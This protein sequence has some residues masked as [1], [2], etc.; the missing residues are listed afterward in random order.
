MDKPKDSRLATT[1]KS[2]LLLARASA[3]AKMA[4]F[5]HNKSTPEGSWDWRTDSLLPAER[6]APL[7]PF[8]LLFGGRR[9]GT[10]PA[11]G[12]FIS[13]IPFRDKGLV[14]SRMVQI[15]DAPASRVIGLRGVAQLMAQKN[16]VSGPRQPAAGR[17][18]SLNC[19]MIFGQTAG[20]LTRIFLVILPSIP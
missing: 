13:F 16:L 19:P 1:I 15:S 6:P 18:R 8:G 14:R 12:L 17:R 4:C 5:H 20:F 9:G 2:P 11:P 3:Y 10:W 7:L